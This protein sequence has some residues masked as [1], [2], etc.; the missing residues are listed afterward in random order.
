MNSDVDIFASLFESKTAKEKL[1]G[2]G[3]LYGLV[4]ADNE[5]YHE[6]AIRLMTAERAGDEEINS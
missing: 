4:R 6:F 3:E 2:L 1:D 5:P